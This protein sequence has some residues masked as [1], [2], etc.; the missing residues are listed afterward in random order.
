MIKRT[1]TTSALGIVL[2]SQSAFAV[3]DNLKSRIEALENEINLLKRQQE[4]SEEKS[5][6]AAATNATVEVGKK[7][8]TVTSPDKQYQLALHG[9]FQLDNRTF[10]NDDKNSQR[11]DFLVRRA[12]PILNVKAGNAGLTFVPDFAGSSTK[13]FDAF[14][15]YKFNDKATVRVG[16]FKPPVGLEQLQS[17]PDN[18]FTERGLPSGL[19][20][21]RDEGVQV[22]GQLVPNILEYQ[23]GVFNG[24]GDLVN[25]DNDTDDKKDVAAR[26]FAKPF[27]NSSVVAIQGLGFGVGG[28]YGKREG[29]TT[30]SILGSYVTAGQQTFFRYRTN[31]FSRGEQWRLDPQ[32][33][34]Y[35]G[36][37]GILAEY[38]ISDQDVVRNGKTKDLQNTAWQVAASYVLTGENVNFS[39]GVKPDRNFSPSSDGWGAFE[40]VA[41]AG[42]L[43]IDSD[44]FPT[45]ADASVSAKKA[46]SYGTGL[47]WYLDENLK[48]AVNYN[49]T[50]FD[51]GDT[52]G[53]DRPEEHAILSRVQF[54]F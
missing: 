47:N 8:L 23:L 42:Q 11:N 22:A 7:G 18:F 5:T 44:T 51:K 15:E 25:G 40:V 3:E 31:A 16:K 41:R 20:P 34:W 6:A 26:V 37:K 35:Y 50:S 9:I 28:S 52:A 10:L 19:A 54:R 33:Y 39:G 13:I 29:S 32:A 24:T 43:L 2:L 17:D 46:T 36:N 30:N 49:Y 48:V 4:V 21:T 38:A 53:K 27:T 1:L 14:A 12:R 45:F